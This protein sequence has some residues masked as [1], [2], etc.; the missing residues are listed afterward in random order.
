M[1]LPRIFFIA[2]ALF[3]VSAGTAS[4]APCWKTLINDWYDGRIDKNYDPQCYRDAIK[5]L[6]PDVE[7]YSNAKD[8]LKRALQNVLANKP[9]N[10][11]LGGGATGNGTSTGKGGSGTGTGGAAGTGT[12]TGTDTIGRNTDGSGPVPDAIKGI[13]PKN[14]DSVPIPLLVLGGL[15]LLLIAAGAAGVVAKRLQGRGPRT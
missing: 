14:A 15:A 10:Q 11:G 12:G 3:F 6:P 9:P 7:V 5:H 2:A 4:A 13:G 8:D 1:K